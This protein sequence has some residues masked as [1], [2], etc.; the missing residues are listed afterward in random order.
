[1]IKQTFDQFPEEMW[2]TAVQVAT[3]W[4]NPESAR[5]MD[6]DGIANPTDIES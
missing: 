3:V 2:V 1:M 5:E 6:A 4:T